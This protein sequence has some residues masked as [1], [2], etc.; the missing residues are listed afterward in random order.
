MSRFIWWSFETTVSDTKSTSEM[1]KTSLPLGRVKSER[2]V[3]LLTV[4]EAERTR[5]RIKD[6]NQ[7]KNPAYESS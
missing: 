3:T 4:G 7:R 2:I 6:A 5:M 1:R